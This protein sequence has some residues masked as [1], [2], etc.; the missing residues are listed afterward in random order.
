MKRKRERVRTRTARLMRADHNVHFEKPPY[1]PALS[2][3]RLRLCA[4]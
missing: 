3:L 4:V 1:P 2:I